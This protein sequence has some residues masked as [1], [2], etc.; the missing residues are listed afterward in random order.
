MKPKKPLT[1]D[2]IIRHCKGWE[3]ISLYAISE[4]NTCK[5]VC[6]DIDDHD[7]TEAEKT[8]AYTFKLVATIRDL[9]FEPLV[10]NSGGGGGWHV[11]L[12]FREPI[13]SQVAYR[14]GHWLVES[15][16]PATATVEVFP[17]QECLTDTSRFG[18]AVRVPGF[19]PKRE[20]WSRIYDAVPFPKILAAST[21]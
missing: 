18:L 13:L 20:A 4:A 21:A 15:H 8:T 3:T 16:C 11:W 6:L 10:E 12:L 7:G 2:T 14:F 5:W 17:S 19:H 1:P 9:G